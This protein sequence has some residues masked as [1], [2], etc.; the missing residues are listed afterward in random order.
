MFSP[1]ITPDVVAKG[2]GMEASREIIDAVKK[3]MHCLEQLNDKQVWWREGENQNSIGNLILHLCGNFRQ[4]IVAGVGGVKDVRNRPSEFS[5]RG[6]IPKAQMVARLEEVLGEAT[7]A[8]SE[9]TAAELLRVRRIQGF[10]VTALKAIFGS[11]SHFVG[12]TQEIIH[13]T[14]HLLGDKYKFLWKPTTPEQGA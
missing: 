10:E 9:T 5:E 2:V 14:R 11:V 1:N 13:M 12:H 8:L 3:I 4:W 7:A 6:P